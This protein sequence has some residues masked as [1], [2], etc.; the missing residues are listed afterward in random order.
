LFAVVYLLRL[1]AMG[2]IARRN[3]AKLQSYTK[4]SAE[5]AKGISIH[6]RN[7]L[8]F[9]VKNAAHW[10]ALLTLK[11]A[12]FAEMNAT[13]RQKDAGNAGFRSTT[14]LPKQKKLQGIARS[15]SVP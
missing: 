3:V 14:T 6:S 7:L 15:T 5:T 13:P 10:R 9:A 11:N 8:F 2:F 4:N 1:A 12:Q